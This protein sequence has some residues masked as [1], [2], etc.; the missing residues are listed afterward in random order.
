MGRILALDYGMKR[1]GVAVTDELKIIAGSLETVSTKDIMTF[2]KD[3]TSKETVETIVVGE[4][5]QMDYTDSQSAGMIEEFI[6]KLKIALPAIPVARADE[7]FTSKMA[8]QVI[9]RSGLK[10]KDRQNKG[11]IDSIS[12]TLILQTYMEG[13]N[14]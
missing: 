7:R 1:V 9:S 3:Y 13:I 5:K 11:L 8:S 6:K 12:A 10:K 2:L 4:P 14:L